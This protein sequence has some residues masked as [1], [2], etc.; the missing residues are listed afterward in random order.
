MNREALALPYPSLQAQVEAKWHAFRDALCFETNGPANCT[1]TVAELRAIPLSVIDPGA[2][3]QPYRATSARGGNNIEILS[4]GKA[5]TGALPVAADP[6]AASN[7]TTLWAT[8]PPF[9]GSFP[10][11]VAD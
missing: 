11:S 8:Q 2:S 6:V 3:W 4:T 9:T 7:C 10:T 5:A 1:F